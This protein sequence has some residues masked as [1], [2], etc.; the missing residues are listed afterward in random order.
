MRINILISNQVSE[1]LARLWHEDDQISRLIERAR[2]R[3]KQST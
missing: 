1:A 3:E 2:A